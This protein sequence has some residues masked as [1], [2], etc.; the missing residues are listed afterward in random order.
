VSGTLSIRNRRRGIP[1]NTRLLRRL[2][3]G[4][5]RDQCKGRQFDL[6]IYLVGTAEITRLNETFLRHEGSTDVITFDHTGKPGGPIHGEIFICFD[7]A[8]SQARRFR[9]TW[10]SELARYA[11]HGVL[12]LCGYDDSRPAARRRM[13]RE[14]NR[15]LKKMGRRFRLMDLGKALCA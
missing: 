13:K 4:V 2:V 12:H 8:I 1:V 10:Q 3:S 7:E 15:V 14:E 5:L 9:S 11:I 6:A